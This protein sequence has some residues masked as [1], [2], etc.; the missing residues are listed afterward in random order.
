MGLSH[1]AVLRSTI[2]EIVIIHRLLRARFESFKEQE[3]RVKTIPGFGRVDAFGTARNK[4]FPQ[5][6]QDLDAPVRFPF[7]WEIGILDWFH[8]DGNT[9]S[10]TE[11]NVGEALGVGVIVDPATGESTIRLDNILRL[12]ALAAKIQPPQW[13]VDVLGP[14]DDAKK[15]AGAKLFKQHC[16]KC[17]DILKADGK[18]KDMIVGIDKLKTDDLRVKNIRRPVGGEGFFDA[19]SPLLK[20]V[21]E[22][23]ETDPGDINMNHWRPSKQ[24]G[25]VVLGYP[26][27]QLR[28][29]WASPPYLHNGSVPNI[30]ELLLP[31]EQRSKKFRL[32]SREYDREKLGYVQDAAATFEFDTSLKGN[33]NVGHDYKNAQFTKEQRFELIEYLK[34]R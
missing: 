14:I 24:R 7:I 22:A 3:N 10:A 18:I 20:K 29:V 34:T 23:A 21:I 25:P 17:H 11:R 30:Y 27:R 31:P 28:S 13:P 9:K 12:E 4:L 26:N 5:H 32:G 15:A 33:S 2:A 19:I 8:W 6:A 16:A 1:N